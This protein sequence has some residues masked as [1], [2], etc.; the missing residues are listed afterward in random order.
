[1]SRTLSRREFLKLGTVGTLGIAGAAALRQNPAAAAPPSEANMP[2]MDDG[3]HDM[4]G[5]NLTTGEVDTSRFDP[6]KY[7]TDFDYGRTSALPTS[8]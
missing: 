7:L 6:M 5:S 3:M 4:E 8:S 1:M 2:G